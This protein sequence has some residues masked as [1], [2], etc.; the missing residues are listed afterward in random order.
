MELSTLPGQDNK[1]R[2]RRDESENRYFCIY[3]DWSAFK[4]SILTTLGQEKDMN[5]GIIGQIDWGVK[6][7][8]RRMTQWL[9]TQPGF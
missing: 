5:K 6:I 7:K 8:Q 9:K 4:P 2:D 1:P 3:Y